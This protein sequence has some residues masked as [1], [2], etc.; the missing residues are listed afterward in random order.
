MLRN[1]QR[2]E[3][4]DQINNIIQHRKIKIYVLK[5]YLDL[6][7]QKQNTEKMGQSF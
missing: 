1:Y 7:F 4:Q 2:T 5:N 6:E 3:I